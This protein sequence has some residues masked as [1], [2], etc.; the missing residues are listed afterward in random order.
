MASFIFQELSTNPNPPSVNQLKVFAKT[1]DNLYV[2]NSSG[3]VVQ[4][5]SVTAVTSLTGDVSGTGPGATST[6]VNFVGGQTAANVASATISANAATSSNTPSTIVKRDGS[7]NF[8]AGTITANITGNLSG[9]V[10]GGTITGL[11]HTTGLQRTIA[12]KTSA[13]LATIND[14]IIGVN[15]TGGSVTITLPPAS[16]ANVFTIL[17]ADSS[18]NTVVIVPSAG[19]NISGQSSITLHDQYDTY[20]VGGDGGTEYYIDAAIIAGTGPLTA[21]TGDVTAIGPGSATATVDY[22]G[23]QTAVAVAYAAT[24]V[25]AAT[26]SNTPSTLVLR[27]ASGNFSAGT[28]TASLIGNVTGNVTGNVSGS[29][30]SFTG[31]LSGDVTGTQGATTI[32][33]TT[34]TGKLLTG[35]TTGS[36]TPITASNTI[37]QAFENLQAQI[38]SSVG[39]AITSLTGDVSATGPGAAAATVNSVGGQSAANIASATVAANAATSSNTASTIVKRD[40]SGNFSAGTITANLTGTATNAT[41]AV[42][43]SGSLSGDVTG[44]QSATVVSFVGGQT[45]TAV[46]AAT[47][48]VGAA[49][50]INTP[51]TLVERDGSGNFS[52]GT[53]TATLNGNASNITATTNTTLT[54]LSSLSLPGSQITGNISGNSANVTGTVAIGNGGTGQTTANAGFNALSP[55]TTVGDMIYE[56]ATPTATR[57]PIGST[58]Q[59]LTVVGGVPA[60][61]SPATNGTVTSVALSTPGVLYTVSGSPVTTSGTLTLNLISQ[62]ANTVFAGPTTGASAA[63][64]FRALVSADIPILNQNTTGTAANI[65]ATSNSTLTTLSALSLP[66]SQVTGNISGNAANITATS[67]NTLTSLPNLTSATSLSITGSQVGGFTPGSVI[68]AGSSGALAQDNA[69]FFWDNTNFT[70]GLGTATPTAASILTG[71]NTTGAARPIQLIGYGVS[72]STGLRGDFA[73]GTSSSP[74]A[75]QNGDILNFISGRGYG[76]SQF[77]TSSTGVI[78]IAAAETFTNTSNATYIAFKTTNTGSVTSAE[79]MRISPAGNLLIGTTTDSGTQKLQVNG[80]SNVGT[81]TAGTWNATDIGVAYGGTG[82]STIPTNGQLLIGNGTGYTVANITPGTGISVTNAAGSITLATNGTTNTTTKTANYTIT[83]NDAI[84]FCDTSGGAFTL[85]L[86]SPTGLAGK[87]YRIIDSTG[88]F[89]SNNLTLSPSASEK[90]EGLAAS[91][92]LQTPWGW[93]NVTTDGTNWFVG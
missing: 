34:V 46:A 6:T 28:I 12:L 37:L 55:M 45:S 77:A 19:D 50:S 79:A 10:T 73:R 92:V 13:Y 52:A 47:V 9:N 41:T 40:A 36:N 74:A 70:L 62:A 2:E 76:T 51:G 24:Q 29:S 48:E 63:P 84:I 33:S 78:Q 4:I 67:N 27:D 18:P 39:S 21:L 72:S 31:S 90:I 15:A 7:G 89:Q 64:T 54:T 8:S 30:S 81:V 5:T 61:A 85:T 75:A 20:T 23:G 43:F 68:F 58:G 42:N 57:L 25:A 59:L 38:S 44:T 53:I 11:I 65:T 16:S 83:T 1:D 91:K 80:N 71:L 87:L 82:I 56:N 69:E 66:G 26:A 86:P 17:K 32:A 88:F 93:F 14:D 3:V 49:T 35:Y 60:W 22:V